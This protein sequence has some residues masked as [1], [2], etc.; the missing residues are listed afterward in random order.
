VPRARTYRGKVHLC[1]RPNFLLLPE[2]VRDFF[3]GLAQ[4]QEE[5]LNFEDA[6]ERLDE[7]GAVEAFED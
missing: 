7:S 5:G 1:A 6:I 3:H 2:G 4:A